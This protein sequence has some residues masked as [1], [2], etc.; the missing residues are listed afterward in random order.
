MIDWHSH[1]LP[2]L[3]DGSHDVEESLT[4]LRMLSEQGVKK[5]VATPHFYANDESVA[6]FIARRQKSFEDLMKVY[7]E[8][9]PDILLGAE[10]RYYTGIEKL[11]D[12]SKL[13]I[14]DSKLLLLEMPMERWTEYTVRELIR[15]ANSKSIKLVLAHIERYLSLQNNDILQK[16]Y[17]SGILMQVNGSFFTGITTKRKAI[18]FLQDG[19]IHFIGSDC[20]NVKNRPPRLEKVY[21][22][23]SKKLGSDNLTR[24][25]E[26]G[27]SLLV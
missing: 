24:F 6:D 16:L 22:I 25:N 9:L 3:D 5:V 8:N 14:G 26:Y 2:S 10:V 12:L 27:E 15:I 7:P 1:V 19:M 17:E 20:H 18:S 13:C 11:E 21:E 23:I 4:L